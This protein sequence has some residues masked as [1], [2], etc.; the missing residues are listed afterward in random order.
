MPETFDFETDDGMLRSVVTAHSSK[1]YR[2]NDPECDAIHMV[3]FDTDGN[4]LCSL[5]IGVDQL[6]KLLLQCAKPT[7][8][9]Q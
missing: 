9:T 7:A 1:T 4:C 8:G 6:Q 3:L 2:C 5:T